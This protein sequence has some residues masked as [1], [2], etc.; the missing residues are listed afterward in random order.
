MRNLALG[1]VLAGCLLGC[2]GGGKSAKD[3]AVSATDMEKTPV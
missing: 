3:K 2:G 1:W